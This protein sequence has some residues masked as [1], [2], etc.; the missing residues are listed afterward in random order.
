VRDGVV[1]RF[2]LDPG[3][4]AALAAPL[5]PALLAPDCNGTSGEAA[6]T[7]PPALRASGLTDTPFFLYPAIPYEH[8]NHAVLVDAFARLHDERPDVQ[9]VLTGRE[10]PCEDALR[11][12]IARLG[13]GRAVVRTGRVSRADLDWL[14][15]HAVALVFPSRYEGFGLP[16]VEAMAAGCPVVAA[17]A[18]ALPEVVDGA[19]LLVAPDDVD[20]WCRAMAELLDGDRAAMTAKSAARAQRYRGDDVA[21][22]LV[23]TYRAAAG[24]R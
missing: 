22:R 18:T 23:A 9:L 7:P 11:A 2:E 16:V 8:K 19:G 15:R 4:V 12:Q 13:L 1:E 24:A 6:S 10:G 17:D 5:P 3:R 21:R 20:G 14:V